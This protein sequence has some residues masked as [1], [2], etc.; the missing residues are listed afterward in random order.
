MPRNIDKIP[1]P[2]T[3]RHA[4]VMTARANPGLTPHEIIRKIAATPAF[5]GNLDEAR[6]Y[7]IWA[8]DPQDAKTRVDGPYIDPTRY[9]GIRWMVMTELGIPD[10]T[11]DS[12]NGGGRRNRTAGLR[13]PAG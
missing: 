9:P 6:R 13:H 8:R 3:K 12:A 7:Y 5:G 10:P 4:A 2:G 11:T 1:L